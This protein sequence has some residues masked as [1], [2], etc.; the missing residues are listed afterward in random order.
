MAAVTAFLL[1]LI[2]L[3]YLIL[4]DSRRSDEADRPAVDP[5]TLDDGALV[6]V[7]GDLEDRYELGF[8]R[9]AIDEGRRRAFLVF[10]QDLDYMTVSGTFDEGGESQ[11][12]R[13]LLT[14]GGTQ[15]RATKGE[16]RA[17]VLELHDQQYDLFHPHPVPAGG[18]VT[19]V[20]GTVACAGL[21]ADGLTIDVEAGFA[22]SHPPHGS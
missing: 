12:L 22:A 11:N 16:C 15:F 21:T 7:N 9:S 4:G 17:S 5:R 8:D 2:G 14:L 13:V 1:A 19:P 3:P 10:N 20:R 18:L 6:L